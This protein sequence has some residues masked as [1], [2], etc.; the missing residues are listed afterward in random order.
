MSEAA[1]NQWLFWDTNFAYSEVT[2]HGPDRI[3]AILEDFML[4]SGV[5]P[6][7]LFAADRKCRQAA[8]F[9]RRASRKAVKTGQSLTGPLAKQ[10]PVP[11]CAGTSSL[12]NTHR[13]QAE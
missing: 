5:Y 2:I 9:A 3:A 6:R 12:A 7:S 8:S 10:E 4:R 11:A 1:R 13:S